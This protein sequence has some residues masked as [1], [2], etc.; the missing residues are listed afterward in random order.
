MKIIITRHAQTDENVKKAESGR[1]SVAMLTEEG[2]LQAKKLADRLKQE[3]ISHAYT[4]PQQRAVDTAKEILEH[5]RQANIEHVVHLKEQDLGIYEHVPKQ[6]WKDAIK[7]SGK[8]LGLFKP[9]K[10][11]SYAELQARAASFFHGLLQ[12]HKE[13]D[14]VLIVSHGGTLGMLLLHILKKEIT[15]ENYK[16]HKPEN[17]ALT[18][19]EISKDGQ[20]DIK[21]LNSIEHLQ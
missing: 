15:E 17:T 5:H 10:G 2:K 4:S 9:E 19:L 8:P 1:L 20:V 21:T 16:G 14:T 12:K 18:I 3:K 6:V 11:E 13:D 7:N